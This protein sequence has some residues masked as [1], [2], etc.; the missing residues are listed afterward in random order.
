MASAELETLLEVQDLDTTVDRLRHR[1]ETLP[2]RSELASLEERR[3]ALRAEIDRVR[4][5]RDEIAARQTQAEGE[6]ASLESRVTEIEKKMYSGTVSASRELQA[7]ADEV[8]SLKRRQSSLEDVALEAM[9]EREPVDA[10]L[11]RLENEDST[12][13]DTAT[14]IELRIGEAELAIDGEIEE[15][16]LRRRDLAARVPESLLE[17]YD[18]IR[19]R[20]D[21]VG[22]ARL[23]G[24]SCTGCHLT[25]PATE[26]DR[27]KKAPADA[28]ILC[29]QCGRILV[30]S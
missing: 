29:D 4:A 17:Q 2:E 27:L 24:T 14:E 21:G 5:Q 3:I 1:R 26:V 8:A 12:L 13:G 7:M 16:T 30:R 15:E 19:A 18:R 23:S 25:L 11:E 20:S 9:T 28:V 6:L 10:E 22:A